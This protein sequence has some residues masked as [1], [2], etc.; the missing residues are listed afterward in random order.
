[1]LR[2]LVLPHLKLADRLPERLPLESIVEPQP[3]RAITRA[4]RA[5][6]RRQPLALKILHHVVEAAIHLADE[7]PHRNAAIVNPF[8][9][10]LACA[11]GRMM[12][13]ARVPLVIHNFWAAVAQNRAG[14]A[15]AGG[16]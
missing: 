6:G 10:G 1:M 12:K 15:A 5:Q 11:H 14:R 7:I 8:V 4:N 9:A 13:S 2:E 3:D 16:P